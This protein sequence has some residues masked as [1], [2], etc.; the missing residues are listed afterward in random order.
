MK[1]VFLYLYPIKEFTKKFISC[2]DFD[3]YGKNY[4]PLVILNECINKRYR[5]NGYQVVF[6]LYPDKEIFGLDKKGN[7][8]VTY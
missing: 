8:K 5:E 6:A 1:K 4:K 3:K 2:R 7:D